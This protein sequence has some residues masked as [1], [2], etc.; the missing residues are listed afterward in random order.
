MFYLEVEITS[1]QYILVM[2]NNPILPG[3]LNYPLG[4]RLYVIKDKW[5][6]EYIKDDDRELCLI[7]ERFQTGNEQEEGFRK[8]QSYECYHRQKE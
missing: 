8:L 2:I 5:H 6:G 3:S 7:N 1:K 4:R